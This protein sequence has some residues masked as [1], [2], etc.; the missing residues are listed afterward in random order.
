MPKFNSKSSDRLDT[1]DP[2]LQSIFTEIV[3]HYDCTILCGYRDKATQDS[4]YNAIP[5]KSKVKWPK[6]KHNHSPSK[7]VDVAP[8]PIPKDWGKEW[9]DRVKFYE[10]AALVF[11]EAH[12][13]GIKIRW[14]GDW[15]SDRDY[16]DN[17]FDDLVHF[18]ITK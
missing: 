15:D 10:L 17:T 3:K 2:R 9:K 18:E 4:Y 16:W 14:G 1:C 12:K 8:W 13:Q 6:S 5:Q 11:Y 7:A